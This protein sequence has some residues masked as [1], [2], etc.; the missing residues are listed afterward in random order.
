MHR[1]SVLL[2]EA[3][4]FEERGEGIGRVVEGLSDDCRVGFARGFELI[5]PDV[6]PEVAPCDPAAFLELDDGVRQSS[7]AEGCDRDL[8]K[9]SRVVTFRPDPHAHDE[10][11]ALQQ[12]PRR[13][14][15][16][17]PETVE[18]C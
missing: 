12:P 11:G 9:V 2:R 15:W 17:S 8:E 16:A 3:G 4:E 5:P 1:L 18:G 10:R 14:E 13:G 7:P 6:S